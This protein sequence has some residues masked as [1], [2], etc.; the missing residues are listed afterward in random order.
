MFCITRFERRQAMQGNSHGQFTEI[1]NEKEFMKI[2]TSEKYVVGHFFHE[3]FRRCKI[4]DTHLEVKKK[5]E[6]HWVGS[7]GRRERER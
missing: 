1:T 6:K 3:D 2:T 7:V 5:I 4:M